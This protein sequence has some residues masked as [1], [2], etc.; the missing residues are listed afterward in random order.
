MKIAI[1]HYSAPPV[2]GGVESVI[3]Q[4]ARFMTAGGHEVTLL[5]GRGGADDTHIRF[6]QVPEMDSRHPDVLVAKEQLDAGQVTEEFL[7]LVSRLR[8]EL[9]DILAGM[10]VVIVH[11]IASLNKNLALTA[12]L[13]E[14]GDREQPPGWI[15]WHHDLAWTTPRYRSELHAGFPWD[16]LRTDWPGAAQVT[17]SEERRVELAHLLG[18]PAARIQVVPNGVDLAQFLKLS[19]AAQIL[20]AELDLALADPLLLMPVRITTRKNIELGLRALASLRHHFSRARL[21][22]TGP[23]GPHNPANLRYFESLLSLR[24]KLDLTHAAHFLAERSSEFVPDE[25]IADLY[26]L[27]DALFLPSFEEGFGIPVLEAGLVGLPVFCSDIPQ[28]RAL[29]GEFATYFA[30]EDPP[31]RVA[32]LLAGRL[33]SE[34]ITGLRRRVKAEYTWQRIYTEKIEP[35]LAATRVSS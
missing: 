7:R 32:Q 2:V 8:D 25:V 33:D 12:A 5:A 35:L 30:P 3:G 27:A 23:L 17:V 16:L 19:E 9:G 28:L 14:L 24:A 18:L 15:L 22:V 11:N 21:L 26:R 10:D 6:L 20:A 1:L 31:E 13:R 4:H 29:G 34:P